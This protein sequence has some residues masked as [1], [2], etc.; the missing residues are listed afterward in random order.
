[1][2]HIKGLHNIIKDNNLV[3]NQESHLGTIKNHKLQAL[4]WQGKNLQRRGIEIIAAAQTVSEQKSYTTQINIERTLIGDI[5][6]AHPGKM[7]TGHK[8]TTWD[9]KWDNYIG[10]MA[11]LLGFPLDYVIRCEMPVGWT[12]ANDHNQF[13]Y[14][15]IYNVPDWEA[16]KMAVYTKTKDCFLDG[17]GRS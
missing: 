6:V 14:Q 8:W 17:E 15:A 13:K 7:E 16:N 9:V 1:M 4:V 11:Q 5:K 12:A 10:T 2:L 3:P